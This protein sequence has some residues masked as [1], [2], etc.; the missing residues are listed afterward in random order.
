MI[1]QIYP[2]H[3]KDDKTDQGFTPIGNL[4]SPLYLEMIKDKN[5]NN[6][7]LPGAKQ[8]G[9]SGNFGLLPTVDGTFVVSHELF[10]GRFLL[11][12]LQALN[13][14]SSIY[15]DP[16][17]G[18]VDGWSFPM[19]YGSDL[20]YSSYTDSVYAFRQSEDGRSYEYAK[21]VDKSC[22]TKHN[23]GS[24]QRE[25]ER[26]STN[27]TAKSTPQINFEAISTY[28]GVCKEGN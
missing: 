11:A 2:Y 19:R 6:G 4:N 15:V 17:W 25:E 27:G 7:Q 24:H 1:H 9:F 23:D 14:A 12:Q 5:G 18:G 22:G 26:R 28:R 13:E 20:N 3:D 16:M 10:M 8:V 21:N